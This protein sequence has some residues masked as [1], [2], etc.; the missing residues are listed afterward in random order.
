MSAPISR[1]ARRQNFSLERPLRVL[2][3]DDSAVVRQ[4]MKSVLST[5]RLIA[6]T[7][8]ADPIVAFEK[9]KKER[10]DVIVSDIQMPRMDGLTFVRKIMAEDAIP[11]VVCSAL[12]PPG[13]D[14]AMRALEEGAVEVIGKPKLGVRDF[15]HESA[16][17]L[18][19]SV[20]AAAHSVSRPH[21][22]LETRVAPKLNADA[23]LPRR[24][25]LLD[26]ASERVVAI[27]ASTGGTEA[28]RELLRAMPPD[29]PGILI[30]Q[31][32]PEVF[33]RVYAERLDQECV[34]EVKEAAS[35]DR[36]TPGRALIAPGNRH[37]LL[38]RSGSQYLVEVK[39]GP[40]V[41]RHRPS[42]DVLFRSV[43]QVA[44]PNAVG[45]I[46]TG[47]GDDGAQGMREMKEAGSFNIAQDEA[48]CMVFG[49]PNE[50]IKHG[51]VDAVLPLHAVAS[52]VLK[53]TRYGRQAV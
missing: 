29:C 38:H 32:M 11:V 5:N 41:C 22:S 16:V 35:G 47:M 15:L 37:M 3:V 49:M 48:S 14:I 31:H 26:I 7:A 1:Q 9:I 36:V 10:P 46:L 23:V 42:V 33:T 40:L 21:P 2:V 12:A 8:A 25:R 18:I 6:V 30:V 17:V 19:D 27:G 28:I 45:V 44:G 24:Q 34:I 4:V 51:G 39:D 53:R 43:A 52:A 13:T 50:A 20:W